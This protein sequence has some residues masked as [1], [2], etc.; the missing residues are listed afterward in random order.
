MTRFGELD[1]VGL[2]SILYTRVTEPKLSPGLLQS[3]DANDA[4]QSSELVLVQNSERDSLTPVSGHS[5]HLY[6]LRD[7][8]EGESLGQLGTQM[9]RQGVMPLSLYLLL[10]CHLRFACQV[11]IT[12]TRVT[13]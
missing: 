11:Y 13:S 10:F 5:L 9:Q 6:V 1:Y 4:L 7:N 3:N 12:L 2:S 8:S